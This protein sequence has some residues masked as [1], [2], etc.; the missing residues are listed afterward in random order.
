MF[1]NAFM[2]R[3]PFMWKKLYMT[4]VRPLAEFAIQAWRPHLKTDINTLE[5]VQ[6]LAKKVGYL[7]KCSYEKRLQILGLTKLEAKKAT[8]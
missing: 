2:S 5:R 7:A 6:M 3:D 8:W 1:R 4:Y